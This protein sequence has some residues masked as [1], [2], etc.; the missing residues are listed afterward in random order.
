LT[1][2]FQDTLLPCQENL[3]FKASFIS[4]TVNRTFGLKNLISA[5]EMNQPIGTTR[6]MDDLLAKM[7]TWIDYPVE[8]F[9]PGWIKI[10][11]PNGLV[12]FIIIWHEDAFCLGAVRIKSEE[13]EE[14]QIKSLAGILGW[15]YAFGDH[16]EYYACGQLVELNENLV[17]VI[18]ASFEEE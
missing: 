3:Q 1:L 11:F 2:I 12:D 13:N 4:Q 5:L 9:A 15:N 16:N 17:K 18:E 6:N 14:E 8:Q 10:V 7:R